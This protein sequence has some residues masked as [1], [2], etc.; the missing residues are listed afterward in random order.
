MKFQKLLLF[1]L[2]TQLISIHSMGQCVDLTCPNDTTIFLEEGECSAVVNYIVPSGI[3][4]CVPQDTMYASF[5]YSGEMEEFIVP[6]GVEFITF[7][8]KGASGGNSAIDNQGQGSIQFPGMGGIITGS[9]PVSAGEVYT[10]FVGGKGG[11]SSDLDPGDPGF[12]GG[13]NGNYG[14]S[15][16]GG[17]GGG[18]SDIRFNGIE[19]EHRIIVAG[20]GG[21]AAVNFLEGGD[22]GGNG[23]D[24]NGQE[25]FSGD[26]DENPEIVEA[27]GGS[28]T[29]GGTGGIYTI[30][31]PGLPGELGIGGNAGNGTSGGGGGGGYYG[32]G[33][34]AWSG[35]AG[36]SS[37]SNEEAF[38]VEHIQGGHSGDGQIILSYILNNA[39]TA[40]LING[41][42]SGASYEAGEYS[43]TWSAMGSDGE[44]Y[45][46][47]FNISIISSL[48]NEI[49]TDGTSLISNSED[50]LYQWVN[51]DDDYTPIPGATNSTFEPDDEGNYALE[52]T[53]GQC[54]LISECLSILD[55]GISE[56]H[57]FDF[58]LYPNPS[59]NR[60]EINSKNTL[61]LS[62]ILI[63]NSLGQV[64]EEFDSQQREF[65]IRLLSPGMYT[66]ILVDKKGIHS[67]KF[68]KE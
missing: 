7:E 25:G 3:D 2:F 65:D 12:N 22:N 54:S 11:N 27:S 55:V 20:G 61:N 36:G 16:S 18:A 49:S 33:G 8:V 38:D 56:E 58:Q 28:Q 32:G 67:K 9:I 26:P 43:E 66:M 23:G 45:E 64:V 50:V 29:E 13:G 4:N 39:V 51:C 30:Y 35:G 21:G 41:E 63:Q 47:T 48:I 31:E 52:I 42:G 44:N 5:D 62:S 14:A 10:I 15:Y 60:I 37:Y 53:S 46:C 19:L 59:S 68:I 1:V 6:D 57:N 17:G 24:L 40:T 34:G